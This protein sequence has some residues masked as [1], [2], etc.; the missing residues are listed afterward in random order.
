MTILIFFIILLVLVLVHEFGHF[1]VAKKNGIRVDEFGFGFPPR[2]FSFKKGETLYSFNAL[3]LGGF[4]KIFGQGM[5]E[6]EVLKGNLKDDGVVIDEKD[7]SKSFANKSKLVQ[8][9]VLLAGIVF[10][11]YSHGFCCQGLLP[12]ACLLR[13]I[14]NILMI[15]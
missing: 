3:P 12:R 13:Q 9:S 8:A 4:V 1:I 2:L 14:Q 6:T 11:Y 10:N 7:I 15:R 5:D